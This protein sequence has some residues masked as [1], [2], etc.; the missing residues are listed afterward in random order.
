ML[1][2]VQTLL[3]LGIFTLVLMPVQLLA[4]RRGWKIA[5]DLPMTWQRLAWRLIGMRV[6][7]VG[8]PAPPPVLMVSNHTSWLDITVLAGIVKPLSFIAKSEVASWPVLG[9]LAKLQRT[10]F[11]DRTRRI[12]AGQV[13]REAGRRVARGETVVL[14]PEG[15]TGDGNRILPFKSALIGAAGLATGDRIPAV[16]P[17]AIVYV[18]IHGLPIG[19][20]DRPHV[21]WYGDMEFVGHFLRLVRRGGMDVTVAFGEPIPFGPDA[22]RKAVTQQ[23]HAE[24]RRMTEALRAGRASPNLNAGQVFSPP[25]KPAKGTGEAPARSTGEARQ[26]VPNRAS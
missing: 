18:G 23:C 8:T 6:T 1:R 13:A 17:V 2:L 22:S 25:A 3:G 19:H 14:F 24:V 9:L 26:E 4:I 16:Q 10:I 7:V 12:D 5:T 20:S 11:I 15:T 21:A